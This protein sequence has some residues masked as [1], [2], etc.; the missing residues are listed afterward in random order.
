MSMVGLPVQ[1]LGRT[2]PL[3][4]LKMCGV[5]STFNLKKGNQIR[6]MSIMVIVAHGSR[7][8]SRVAIGR[9]AIR[10]LQEFSPTSDRA[11]ARSRSAGEESS[12]E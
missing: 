3:P 9:K 7:F 2:R 1:G 4:W 8:T 10:F 6:F 5:K 12:T 11:P